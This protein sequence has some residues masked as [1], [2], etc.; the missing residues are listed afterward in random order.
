MQLICRQGDM[1]YVPCHLHQDQRWLTVS[2]GTNETCLLLLLVTTDHLFTFS[3]STSR[4]FLKLLQRVWGGI[5]T[6][7]IRTMLKG[8]SVNL[9][10]NT[11]TVLIMFGVSVSETRIFQF[12]QQEIHHIRS[13][14]TNMNKG[15]TEMKHSC[16]LLLTEELSWLSEFENAT[17]SL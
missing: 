3:L 15:L 5:Q 7:F 6:L 4:Y 12:L 14:D 16:F 9:W 1:A 11:F 10:S 13:T 8:Q 2:K 17:V